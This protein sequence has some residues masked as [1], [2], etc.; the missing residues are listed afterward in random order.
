MTILGW[1]CGLHY[2][3][4]C[5]TIGND[6]NPRTG[7]P[8]FGMIYAPMVDTNGDGEWRYH[9][10]TIMLPHSGW[11]HGAWLSKFK[12]VQVLPVGTRDTGFFTP[13]RLIE[14]PVCAGHGVIFGAVA[15]ITYYTPIQPYPSDLLGHDLILIGDLLN[16]PAPDSNHLKKMVNGL[17]SWIL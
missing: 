8:F 15:T 4:L 17:N 5:L 3:S 6:K 7:N 13:L 12:L 11:C 2:T 16:I 1:W 9:M 10:W 14:S